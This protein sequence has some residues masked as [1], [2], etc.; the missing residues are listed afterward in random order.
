MEKF[1]KDDAVQLKS[2]DNSF[3][4]SEDEHI[5]LDV[6]NCVVVGIPNQFTRFED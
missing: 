3:F 1:N 6:L 5:D 2:D 4:E